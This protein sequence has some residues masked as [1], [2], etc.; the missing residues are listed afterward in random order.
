L[1]ELPAHRAEGLLYGLESAHLIAC[2]ERGRWSMHDLVRLY[3]RE[4]LEADLE[5]YEQARDRLLEYYAETA[6][7][8]D[9]H[10][11]A[12]VSQPVPTGFAG[13]A[14]ALEW[15][16]ADRAN[17][18]AAVSLAAHGERL[19]IAMRLPLILANYFAWRRLFP[20]L[21]ESQSVAATAARTAGHRIGE[22]MAL[23]NLGTVLREVGRVEEAIDIEQ[24][25]A[26]CRQDQDD[27]FDE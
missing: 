10:L 11:K 15:F 22:A 12:L 5:E 16:D 7:A 25:A 6:D 4:L 1:A 13:R 21:I 24:Q 9:D 17:L 14:Q 26:D 2:D 27:Q 3:A 23:N 18:I 19:D 20:E 8:A